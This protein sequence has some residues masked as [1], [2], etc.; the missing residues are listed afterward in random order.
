MVILDFQPRSRD[1]IGDL[2]VLLLYRPSHYAAHAK[3]IFLQMSATVILPKGRVSIC[4]T[5][6]KTLKKTVK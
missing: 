3:M 5:E 1:F 4:I 6:N 2:F